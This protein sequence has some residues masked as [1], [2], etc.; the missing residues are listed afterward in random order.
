MVCADPYGNSCYDNNDTN[1]VGFLQYTANAK[2][3]LAAGTTI[4]PQDKTALPRR[5]RRPKHGVDIGTPA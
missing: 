4:P 5:R 3:P 1:N 2:Y